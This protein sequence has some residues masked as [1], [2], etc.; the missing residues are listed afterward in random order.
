VEAEI[1]VG[2]ATGAVAGVVE[3]VVMAEQDP[4]VEVGGSAGVPGV[5]VVGVAPG[6]GGVA[7]FGAAGLVADEECLALGGG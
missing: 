5:D 1:A 6:T 4:V 3:A 2:K 7:A